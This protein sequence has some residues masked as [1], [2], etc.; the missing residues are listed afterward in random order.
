M[1]TP[2]EPQIFVRRLI[3]LYGGVEKACEA[4]EGRYCNISERW[5]QDINVIG[6]ILRSHLFVEYYLTKYLEARNP[7]LCNLDE[8]RLTFAQKIELISS[9]DSSVSYL[10][11]GIKRLNRV[12]NKLAHTLRAEVTP[13]D[14]QV[15]LSVKPFLALRDAL[16]APEEPSQDPIC[17]LEDFAKHV[18]VM[19]ES[20][21][22]PENLLWQQAL[23]FNNIPPER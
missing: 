4:F 8:A 23:G 1:D 12:R 15:F 20:A 19:L 16:A 3:E 21:S 5:N 17:I 18:G 2:L 9:S 7:N 6:R 10:I 11:S 13:E 22:N 14:C